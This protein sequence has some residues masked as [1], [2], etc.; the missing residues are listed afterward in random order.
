MPKFQSS[1]NISKTGIE[2][3]NHVQKHSDISNV[4]NNANLAEGRYSCLCFVNS[5]LLTLSGFIPFGKR[6]IQ[7]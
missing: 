5:F 7:P 2:S 1:R 6:N 4:K 3:I